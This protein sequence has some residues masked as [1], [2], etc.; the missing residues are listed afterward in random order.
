MRT[1]RPAVTP[2][3]AR[4]TLKMNAI[5]TLMGTESSNEKKTFHHQYTYNDTNGQPPTDICLTNTTFS[6]GDEVGKE[7]WKVR[8]VYDFTQGYCVIRTKYCS[9]NNRNQKPIEIPKIGFLSVPVFLTYFS[10]GPKLADRLEERAHYLCRVW[11][12]KNE[13]IAPQARTPEDFNYQLDDHD[14]TNNYGVREKSVLE[15]GLNSYWA[16]KESLDQ[17]VFHLTPQDL[18]VSLRIRSTVYS[19]E[20]ENESKRLFGKGRGYAASFQHFIDMLRDDNLKDFCASAQQIVAEFPVPKPPAR[21][22]MPNPFSWIAAPSIPDNHAPSA[23]A[24]A[25]AGPAPRRIT[26]D[27]VPGD[28]ALGTPNGKRSRPFDEGEGGE[29]PSQQNQSRND[30]EGFAA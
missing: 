8:N 26:P 30:T 28:Q 22:N 24:A 18:Q 17:Q 4:K 23:R 3:K 15:I 1:E 29:Q 12:Q 19:F 2:L 6:F 27:R 25:A 13:G 5:D 21:E 7:F 14:W 16:S 20:N 9:H 10:Q 11:N